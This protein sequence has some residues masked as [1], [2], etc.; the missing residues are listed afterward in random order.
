MK[1]KSHKNFWSALIFIVAGA[2]ISIYGYTHY[3]Y[4]SALRMGPGY[5]PTWL[6]ALTFLIGLMVMVQAFTLE[7]PTVPRFHWRP[8]LFVLGGVVLFGYILKPAGLVLSIMILAIVSAYGGH[9]FKWKEVVWLA[10]A[11]AIFSVLVFVK[12]L[13]QPFPIWPAFID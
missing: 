7:G 9:E 13:G 12:L 1:I 4:G 6:G 11:L 5:F 2:F 8:M 3:Q 10:I